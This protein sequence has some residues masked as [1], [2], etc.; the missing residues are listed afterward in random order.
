MKI[1]FSK[2]GFAA[3]FLFATAF[4]QPNIS[5]NGS[6]G[7][8][9]IIVD[10]ID[11]AID[12]RGVI[13]DIG[14]NALFPMTDIVK[15]GG[16]ASI[17]Y[18]YAAAYDGDADFAISAIILGLAPKL[19]FGQEKTYADVDLN[20]QIPLSNKITR[21]EHGETETLDDN[22]ETSFAV[23]LFGRYNFIGA[24]I[25][26]VLTDEDNLFLLG[27][28]AFIS[29]FEQF[30]IIPSIKYLLQYNGKET[31]IAIGFKYSL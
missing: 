25:G 22:S 29:V 15:I 24:G 14:A 16:E 21:E 27:A 30:E 13:L 12:Y 6:V 31:Q 17:A 23:Y 9:R 11:D 28:S 7:F 3:S 20:V 10:V 18:L 5:I 26:K 19:R 8:D 2:I 1:N 4:A